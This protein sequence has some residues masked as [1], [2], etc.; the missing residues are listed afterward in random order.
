MLSALLLIVLALALLAGLL[1]TRPRGGAPRA[2][3]TGRTAELFWEEKVLRQ[4]R[5]NRGAMERAVTAKRRN[6]PRASR[7]AL[8]E[9]DH[10]E[11]VRDR[12]RS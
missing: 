3:S 7:A 4:T 10:D 1:A 2:S 5:G 8:L 11:Y 6:H 12:N 9:M